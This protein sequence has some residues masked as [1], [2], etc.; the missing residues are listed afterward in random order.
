MHRVVRFDPGGPDGEL[1]AGD[2]YVNPMNGFQFRSG[3]LQPMSVQVFE[4][5]TVVVAD[6]GNHRIVSFDEWE[7][8]IP[9]FLE[10]GNLTTII[11]GTGGGPTTELLG[12]G[13]P[14]GPEVLP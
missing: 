11:G 8:R 13:G 1:L 12:P 3:L 7:L 5:G 4:D 6:A 2:N 10:I 14:Y 9:P